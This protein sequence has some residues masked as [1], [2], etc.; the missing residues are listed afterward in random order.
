MEDSKIR[1]AG[2]FVKQTK[3]HANERGNR[4]FVWHSTTKDGL[5]ANTQ[6]LKQL[7]FGGCAHSGHDNN[8]TTNVDKFPPRSKPAITRSNY[9]NKS[10]WLNQRKTNG[11]LANQGC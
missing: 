7:G 2:Y 3:C 5:A 6:L 8:E 10:K 11:N 1:Q 9:G 4:L